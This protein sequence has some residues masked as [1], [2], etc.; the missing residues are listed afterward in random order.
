MEPGPHIYGHKKQ[1]LGLYCP[2]EV[3]NI[4]EDRYEHFVLS[5]SKS[6]TVIVFMGAVV[7]N[8]IHVKLSYKVS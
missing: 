4:V 5:H 3:L 2:K 8:S 6:R 7:N 1:F